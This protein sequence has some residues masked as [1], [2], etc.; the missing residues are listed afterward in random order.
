MHELLLPYAGYY[1]QSVTAIH[2]AVPGPSASWPTRWG[3]VDAAERHL[4]DAVAMEDRMGALPARP[5]R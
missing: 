4:A 2:G 3:Q 1:L 5:V